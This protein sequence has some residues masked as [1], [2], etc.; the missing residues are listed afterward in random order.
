MQVK[1]PGRKD[2]IYVSDF[3]DFSIF[4]DAKVE[5]IMSENKFIGFTR[6]ELLQV[7]AA[8]GGWILDGY[9]SIAYLLVFSIH[10]KQMQKTPLI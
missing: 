6:N 9:T 1:N 2:E 10:R 3:L 4:I 8:W 7:S 5:Y